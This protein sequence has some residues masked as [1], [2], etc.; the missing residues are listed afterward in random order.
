MGNKKDFDG[1]THLKTDETIGKITRQMD[2]SEITELVRKGFNRIVDNSMMFYIKIADSS[3]E[4]DFTTRSW[5][6]RIWDY[7][8]EDGVKIPFGYSQIYEFVEKTSDNLDIPADEVVKFVLRLGV[9]Q[10]SLD[11]EMDWVPT[12]DVVDVHTRVKQQRGE[13]NDILELDAEVDLVADMDTE[14]EKAVKM[15]MANKPFESDGRL[16]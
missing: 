13:F 7:F 14:S 5:L 16:L 8:F 4:V 11:G 10:H 6:G 2:E 12:S 15:D 9:L 3:V 1:Y